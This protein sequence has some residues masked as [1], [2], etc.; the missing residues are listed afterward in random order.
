MKE[1]RIKVSYLV[2]G[3]EKE[4]LFTEFKDFERLVDTDELV[5]L[6]TDCKVIVYEAVRRTKEVEVEVED[7]MVL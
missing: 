6:L 4:S 1:K 3:A 5:R 7:W 2:K